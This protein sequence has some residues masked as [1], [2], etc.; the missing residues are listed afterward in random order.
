M[1][2]LRGRGKDERGSRRRVHGA[3]VSIHR[4]TPAQDP[5]QFLHGALTSQIIGAFYHIYNLFGF[6]F[7]ESVYRKALA[8]E[9]SFRGLD[10]RQEVPFRLLHRGV[11]IGRYRADL[12]VGD[13][14]VVEVKTGLLLD[15]VAPAQLLNYLRASS[16]P[17]GL[18]LHAG[19]RPAIKRIVASRGTLETVR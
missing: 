3:C 15:P 4:S 17:V 7:L 12:I 8:V 2:S 5:D 6:G 19:P 11:E 9:L 18:V 16:L 1:T 13:A 10:V 14:V